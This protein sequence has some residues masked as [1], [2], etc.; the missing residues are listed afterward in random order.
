MIDCCGVSVQGLSQNSNAQIGVHQI[1][2]VTVVMWEQK[3]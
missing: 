2:T 1:A 3:E